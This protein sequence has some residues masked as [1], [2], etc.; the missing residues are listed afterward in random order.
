M[1]SPV[2][3]DIAGII[4]IIAAVFMT[5]GL[6]RPLFVLWGAQN[7]SRTKVLAVYGSILAISAIIFM[8]TI[9]PGQDG[10]KEQDSPRE[11]VDQP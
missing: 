8:V 5:I 9:D 10:A 1:N 3:H 11:T 2:L 4:A 6:I 7:P